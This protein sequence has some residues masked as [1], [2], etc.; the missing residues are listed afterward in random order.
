MLDIREVRVSA[1]KGE[2]PDD[3]EAYVDIGLSSE[4]EA[5]ELPDNEYIG[6][7]FQVP[8]PPPVPPVPTGEPTPST[9]GTTSIQVP[10][11][12]LK[13]VH[14]VLGQLLQGQ[15]ISPGSIGLVP[16]PP[17]S[18]P[19]TQQHE[20]MC[21]LKFQSSRGGKRIVLFVQ[22]SSTQQM[23]IGDI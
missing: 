20:D 13:Q 8:L 7:K 19:Q 15:Q 4:E 14:Q 21:L 23:H 1:H 12:M 18:A 22:G 5:E 11:E 6:R 16:I 3:S 2:N 10:V 17:Q 9:S